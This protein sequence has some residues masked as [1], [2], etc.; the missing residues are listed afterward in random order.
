[1]KKL[2]V[3]CVL[4]GFMVV[5]ALT[6]ASIT[7]LDQY[8]GMSYTHAKW[9]FTG[10]N[11]YWQ[12]GDHTVSS[13]VPEL[14]ESNYDTSGNGSAYAD[15]YLHGPISEYAGGILFAHQIDLSLYIPNLYSERAYK[16]VQVEAIYRV[17]PDS[18]GGLIYSNLFAPGDVQLIEGP[19]VTGTPGNWQDVTLTWKVSP[20]PDYE[21]IYLWLHDSG[22]SLDSVEVAT[23]C[24]PAPGA[25][26]L[27]SI[28][29]TLVGWLRRRKTL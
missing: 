23:V 29:V 20:Q 24:I 8:P 25:I 5:P 15:A 2:V 21:W 22:V 14:W 16:L 13:I 4:V 10:G 12:N 7:I 28:G 17:C 9:E 6:M 27:G 3:V 26:L 11:E 18:G 1:M 19:I